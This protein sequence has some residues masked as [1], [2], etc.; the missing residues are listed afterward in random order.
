MGQRGSRERRQQALHLPFVLHDTEYST[1]PVN[2]IEEVPDQS[3]NGVY[4]DREQLRNRRIK[5][6]L[7]TDGHYPVK[8]AT[9]VP[10]NQ[11]K[12]ELK[13]HSFCVITVD[14]LIDKSGVYEISNIQSKLKEEVFTNTPLKTEESIE[15]TGAFT[16]FEFH[17]DYLKAQASRIV[18]AWVPVLNKKRLLLRSHKTGILQI[19]QPKQAVIFD[20]HYIDEGVDRSVWHAG[21]LDEIVAPGTLQSYAFKFSI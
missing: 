1:V 14:D 7:K 17:Q 10:L 20:S 12:Q 2:C 8:F 6:A 21:F 3:F 18:H 16:S 9:V 11:C 15:F 19:T 13:E 5:K 4:I